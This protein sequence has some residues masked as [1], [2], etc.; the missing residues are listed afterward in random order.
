MFGMNMD[1]KM[2]YHYPGNYHGKISNF[3]FVDTHAEGHKWKDSQI[4]N[5]S[6]AP[7]NWHDHTGN[8]A[9]PSSIDDLNW[10]KQ[11]TTVRQ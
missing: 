9:K 8:S 11:N 10:L 5:P 2:I 6:P 7:P 1:S 4:N 3:V